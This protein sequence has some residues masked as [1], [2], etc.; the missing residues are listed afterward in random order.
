MDKGK[1]ICKMIL[2]IY[3][4]KYC[5]MTGMIANVI[6][7]TVPLYKHT[8][9]TIVCAKNSGRWKV[10]WISKQYVCVWCVCVCVSVCIV[11]VCVCVCVCLC[12]RVGLCHC[13]RVEKKYVKNALKCAGFSSITAQK[14]YIKIR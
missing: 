4:T 13:T 6:L 7:M 14:R 10:A 3:K 11:C 9:R 8:T 12:V 5:N 2:K 1:F